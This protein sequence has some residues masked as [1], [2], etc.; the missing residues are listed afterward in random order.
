MTKRI[1]WEFARDPGFREEKIVSHQRISRRGCR[2]QTVEN[3]KR[4]GALYGGRS[5]EPLRLKTLRLA[6]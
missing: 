5:P 6:P 2:R 4:A 3:A 1:R